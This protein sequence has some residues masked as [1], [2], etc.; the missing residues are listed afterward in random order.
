MNSREL[1]T[2][3]LEC[4]LF[5]IALKERS[6]DIESQ[7]NSDFIDGKLQAYKDAMAFLVND[8]PIYRYIGIRN[9]IKQAINSI[10]E[11]VSKGDTGDDESY[12]YISGLTEILDNFNNKDL[13]TRKSLNGK[14]HY[15][16]ESKSSGGT[17]YNGKQRYVGEC[18][19]SVAI[20]ANR[21]INRFK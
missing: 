9:W 3:Q 13:H 6:E 15:F 2:R 12:G 7:D 11:Y 14:G 10:Q 1:L 5:M 21:K 16:T 19:S 18:G 4:N 20:F 17:K 8:L